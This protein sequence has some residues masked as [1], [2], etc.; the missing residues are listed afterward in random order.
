MSGFGEVIN[1]SHDGD[2]VSEIG[3]DI[4]QLK[5]AADPS[6]P[7]WRNLGDY[8]CSIEPIDR[9]CRIALEA[10]A[11]GAQLA[12]AGCGGSMMAL[13]ADAQADEVISAMTRRYYE[14]MGLEP[15][16]WMVHPASGS[17][18]I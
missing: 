10:G 4:Q 15:R 6:L 17:G 8:A 1:A 7:L 9:M 5:A 16:H 12:G 2:R 11:L 13:L 3:P 18:L 14:P